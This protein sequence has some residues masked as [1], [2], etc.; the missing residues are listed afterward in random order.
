MT[1]YDAFHGA[2]LLREALENAGWEC[3]GGCETNEKACEAYSKRFKEQTRPRDI[4]EVDD[5][6]G[7]RALVGGVPCQDFSNAGSRA[8]IDGSRS[9]LWAEFYRI[10]QVC[11]P[12]IVVVEN[13]TGIFV[14]GL[15]VILRDL[16]ASGYYAEWDCFPASA[17]GAPHPRDRIALVA[18]TNSIRIRSKQVSI[19]G[20][21]HPSWAGYDGKT[22]W[23]KIKPPV[24]AV[25][26]GH[27]RGSFSWIGNGVVVPQWEWIGRRILETMKEGHA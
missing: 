27:K 23:Q 3:V 9:G 10:I 17:F 4:R 14:R 1:F 6:N 18:Y 8:G 16:A 20:S 19:Q 12:R 25:D 2:G 15:G 24:Y 13:V 22:Y 7:A 11:H 26:D 21:S 5:I